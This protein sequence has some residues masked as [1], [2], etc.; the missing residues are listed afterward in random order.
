MSDQQANI[1][2]ALGASPIVMTEGDAY[3]ALERG[4]A[5]GRFKEWDGTM[6][7]KINEVTKYRTDNIDL[8]MDQM[9]LIANKDFWNKLPAD[10]QNLLKGSTSLFFSHYHG[11]VYDQANNANHALCTP[12][13][14]K[15]GNPDTYTLPDTE[16]QKWAQAVTPITQQWVNDMEAKGRPGKAALQDLQN[17]IKQYS[18]MYQIFQ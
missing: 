16:K 9:I 7:W 3:S 10:M 18:Q 14:K 11:I 1:I 4:L 17:W 13:D 2:K 6:T 12:Y 5:D 8:G 15:V